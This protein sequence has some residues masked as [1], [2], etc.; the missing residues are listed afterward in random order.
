M[1]WR[2]LWISVFGFLG[3][4]RPAI[5]GTGSVF[6]GKVVMEDGSVPS[7][8]VAIERFCGE[9]PQHI[10]ATNARG[11]YIWHATVD[12]DGSGLRSPGS[13]S[14]GI[15][16]SFSDT[17]NSV[18]R[19]GSCAVR[20]SLP[21]YESNVIDV[22]DLTSFSNPVLPTLVLTRRGSQP[23]FEMLA[24]T[25]V[26]RASAGAWGRA[27][28]L[29]HAKDWPG[30]EHQ[31]RAVLQASPRFAQGWNALGGVLLYEQ[32]QTEAREA[33]QH[34]IASNPRLLPTYL[35]VARLSVA[36]QDWETTAKTAAALMKADPKHQYPEAYLYEAIARYQTKDIDGAEASAGEAL[37]L[38]R[39]HDV[40][41]AEYVYGLILEAKHNY[42]S[43][44][45]HMSRYLDLDPK[46][47]DAKTVRTRID[48]LGK[49]GAT[50]V[51]AEL[52]GI[53]SNLP[54]GRTGVAWVPGGIKALANA[55]HLQ[56]TPASQNFF[57][58]YCRAIANELSFGT[59]QG[60]PHY[61]ETLRT[62]MTSVAALSL[63]G[64]HRDNRTFV[65]LSLR[66]QAGRDLAARVLPLLGWKLV[67]TAGSTHVEP[68]DQPD[69]GNKQQILAFLGIDAIDMQ[70]A[71]ESTQTFRFDLPSDDARL[72]GGDSWS[73]LLR[74]RSLPGGIAAAFATDV[75]LA[76]AYA[77][78]AAMAPDAAAAL[79]TGVGLRTL[80][81]RHADA[82]ARY[83][84]AFSVS[85]NHAVIP[86]GAEAED[87]WKQLAGASPRD[88]SAFFR[89]LLEKDQG[90]LAAF[91]HV[92]WST[93]VARQRF[94]T[95]SDKAAA[96]FYGWY[97]DSEE[98]RGGIARHAAGWR[99]S[100]FR[101]LPMEGEAVRFPGGPKVWTPDNLDSWEALVPLTRIEERRKAPLDPD[102][103]SLLETHYREWQPLFPYFEKLSGLGPDHFRA[104][105]AF[106]AAVAKLSPSAE[107]IALGEWYSLLELIA[108]GQAAGSLDSTRSAAAFR[109]ICDTLGSNDPSAG[110]LKVLREITGPGAELDNAVPE[111]LLRLNAFDR[112]AFDRVVELQ[113]IPRLARLPRSPEETLA[114]LSGIVYA[115]AFDPNGLL[116]NEDPQL[117]RKHQFAGSLIF[118]ASSLVR[119]N[120]SPGSY[121][122]GG[123]ANLDRVTSSLAVSGRAAAGD[124]ETR[125]TLAESAP[126]GQDVLDIDPTAVVFHA[127]AQLVEVYAA[128]TDPA[129][130]FVD[131]LGRDAFTVLDEGAP[132]KLT[133][134]EPRASE[135]AVALVLDTTGSMQGALPAL[136]NAALRL[137]GELRPSDQVAVYSFDSS[138][139]ELQPF[140]ADKDAAKRAVM[141]TQA[142]GETA[143]FDALT[144]VGRDLSG[145]AGKKVIVVFTDGNDNSSTLT[146]DIAILRAKTAGIPVYTIAQGEALLYPD[147][148]KQLALI[149]RATGGV[150]FI[151]HQPGE[152]RGVF[153]K[154]S[155]DLAHGYLL[156]FQPA[157]GAEPSWHS[158]QI[159]VHGSRRYRVRAREGY[160]PK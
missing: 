138:L 130:H 53:A 136:K 114:A 40:P 64:E 43:A 101:S 30:A 29:V 120:T 22:D 151:I 11:E 88:A 142:F 51:G 15:V 148:I 155:E 129:G 127:G 65:T 71:L 115:A 123:F 122:R 36:A 33:Y 92:L 10:A 125:P 112:R 95:R 141:G 87:V 82:L 52:E 47:T 74:D 110:A 154:L 96:A 6:R 7:R 153:E 128:V 58:D 16:G 25:S 113:K 60:I 137:I 18:G 59:G 2:L 156:V 107:N 90:R 149:S 38:D 4:V 146:S 145:R 68:G 45:E 20:A 55:A 46:A 78:L 103:A 152:I 81:T 32:K 63:I 37:R 116:V 97:R 26:P 21:G 17:M 31:L 91:Y 147:F 117:L 3:L 23:N 159:E 28:K 135:V 150:S 62:Y 144:R 79:V 93:D 77:G 27:V 19:N 132:Q 61:L 133:A 108:R 69:D 41:R 86:G 121:L 8:T 50:D 57:A 67:Q 126:P 35:A 104:L 42:S 118:S 5:G 99:T 157:S 12:A 54:L 102:S 72:I 73:E 75:R 143:L 56:I 76:Q 160:Y 24:E 14:F 105:A 1:V 49:P 134:F 98:F 89:A 70:Q 80:V 44:G 9:T 119:S 83:G 66:D 85:N 139:R 111:R 106:T 124:V 140:T 109:M 39:K 158:L 13:F 94:F 84:E 48:N 131:D 34:A 100:L